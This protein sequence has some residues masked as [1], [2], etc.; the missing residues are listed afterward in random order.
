M[1]CARDARKLADYIISLPE[2][3]R[4][5][6]TVNQFSYYHIGALFTNVVLQAGLN[7]NS[8]VKPRV[9]KVL[10]N[11]PQDC[12]VTKFQVVINKEGLENIIN[13]KHSVKLERFERLLQFAVLNNVDSCS[14]L[15]LFFYRKESYDHFLSMNGFGPKS[16]DYLLKLLNIDN[17][18]VDR[19]IYSF[20]KMANI[21]TKG[22]HQTKK[23][24][25]YAADF[26]N[27]PRSTM[28]QI[29]WNYMSEKRFAS[30]QSQCSF[31]FP[32]YSL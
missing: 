13:W 25:E 7:Y 21:D 28:D 24:V 29:I 26:L 14:D 4:A 10:S 15:E 20:V 22:Y 2:I 9:Q 1:N 8:V 6:R 31:E 5:C 17:V 27:I 19:H 3:H 16:L 18:A 30:C 12:T 11:Y 23:V 32:E